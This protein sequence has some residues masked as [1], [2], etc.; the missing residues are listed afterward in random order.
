MAVGL[1]ALFDV[2]LYF[3]CAAGLYFAEEAEDE[4]SDAVGV[5]VEGGQ[6]VAS[7][8]GVPFLPACCGVFLAEGLPGS[9]CHGEVYGLWRFAAV[10]EKVGE[11]F[12]VEVGVLPFL[13]EE[14]HVVHAGESEGLVGLAFGLVASHVGVAVHEGE[15]LHEAVVGAGGVLAGVAS[16]QDAAV[17]AYGLEDLHEVVLGPLVEEL[18]GERFVLG[19]SLELV[20]QVAQR[21]LGW[22]TAHTSW[23]SVWASSRER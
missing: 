12:A 5:A 14:L 8:F 9:A 2:V 23:W 22:D 18:C 10:A 4:A 7:G 1:Y 6:G 17:C 19:Q 15:G 3:G 21:G 20:A 11:A 13:R 16:Q